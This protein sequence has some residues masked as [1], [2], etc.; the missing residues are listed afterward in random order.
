MGSNRIGL[1]EVIASNTIPRESA[2]T[3]QCRVVHALLLRDVK[4]RY[5][6]RRLGFTWALIEPVLFITL[7]VGVFHLIGRSSQSGIEAPLFFITGFSPFFMFRDVLSQVTACTKSLSPLLM[8]PQVSRFDILIATV[9]LETLVAFL[10]LFLLLAGCYL[11][12]YTFTIERPLDVLAALML[13]VGLSTGLGLVLGALTIRYEFV[14]A[15]SNALLSRPLFLA[16]GL[17]FTADVLPAE[18]R[19]YALF[20]PVLHCIEAIRSAIFHSFES[21]YVDLQYVIV[22]VLILIGF[23][24]LLADFFERARR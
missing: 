11:M 17:F 19:Y 6:G 23:G 24:L 2:F 15:F 21:R 12:G 14:S 18:A 10:V 1:P 5:G 7:F 3:I 16:S 22:F 20:N 4:A 9:I 13:L 8:F